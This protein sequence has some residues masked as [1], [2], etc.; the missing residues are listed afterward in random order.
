MKVLVFFPG[1]KTHGSWA[2]YAPTPAEI[3][4]CDGDW[5]AAEKATYN[6]AD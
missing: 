4:A 6:L 2:R 5:R 1:G 3:A